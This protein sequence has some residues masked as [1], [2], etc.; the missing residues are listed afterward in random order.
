MI[1]DETFRK[2]RVERRADFIEYGIEARNIRKAMCRVCGKTLGV[3]K[4][5][6]YIELMADFY[7]GSDRFVCQECELRTIPI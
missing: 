1:D 3:G 7:R 2:W 6:R 4:G 5:I